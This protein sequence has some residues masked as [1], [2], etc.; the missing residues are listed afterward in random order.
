MFWLNATNAATI[1][2]GYKDIGATIR[3]AQDGEMSLESARGLLGSLN[4]EWLLLVDGADD[5]SAMSGLW[6]PGQH[7]DI[8]YTSR[9]PFLKVLAP[10]A[11]CE[12]SEMEDL[13]A[14]DLLLD[15]ARLK[16]ASDDVS[17]RAKEIVSELGNLALAVDQAGAF[18]ARG[19]CRI[20]DFL[21]TFQRHRARL[22]SVDAYNHASPDARAVYATWELSYSVIQRIANAGPTQSPRVEAARNAMTLL[23]MLAYF[24]YESITEDV[25]KRAAEDV[26]RGFSYPLHVDPERLLAGDDDLP[27]DLLP[28]DSA[29][30]WD[31]FPFRKCISLLS[32]YSILW[33]NRSSGA[34]SMHRLVHQ[35][36]FDRMAPDTRLASLRS[37]ATTLAASVGRS[38][39][40]NN[41][42]ICRNLL[43]HAV[44]LFQ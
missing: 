29:M 42:A 34:I 32:S 8:L 27:R 1:E 9:N 7:G 33:I 10:D 25:F 37:S 43:P 28:L 21:G 31:A 41:Y 11:V 36:L 13:D 44:V 15:A 22:L 20:D 17:R 38:D 16:P 12:V 18:I 3:G 39:G 6:P 23:N 35:W 30:Q 24:H 5:V 2:R 26:N 14:V 40:A 4:D 19:E